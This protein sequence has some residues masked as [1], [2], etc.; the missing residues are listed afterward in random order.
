MF[1][2]FVR[3]PGTGLQDTVY[4][5]LVSMKG[6]YFWRGMG[7]PQPKRHFQECTCRSHFPQT[8]SKVPTAEY[9]TDQ[10]PG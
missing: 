6:V 4:L 3:A 8:P 2:S 5:V 10:G 1:E 9:R 7:V